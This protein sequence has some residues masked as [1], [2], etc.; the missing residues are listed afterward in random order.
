MKIVTY[1]IRYALGLDG[2]YDYDRITDAVKGADIIA[3]QEVERHW[4]RSEMADQV[5]EI[6]R[7]LPDYHH[8]YFPALDVDASDQIENGPVQNRRRQFGPMLLSRYPIL[9]I[10]RHNLPK[11]ATSHALN[12]DTGALECVIDAPMGPI[13][14]YSLHL[15]ASS[16]REKKAQLQH[17]MDLHRSSAQRGSAWT[18]SGPTHDPDEMKNYIAMDWSNGEDL[19]LTPV[20]TVLLGD[21]NMTP[22]GSDYCMVVGEHDVATGRGLHADG[23]ADSWNF[24]N[25]RVDDDGHTWWPDPPNRTPGVP[26]RLD[27]CFVSPSLAHNIDHAWVDES[28]NGSDH[29]PYWVEVSRG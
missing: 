27:Y 8:A 3:L 5:S 22:E 19:P 24:A 2:V 29:K 14:A 9:E 17:L 4:R 6:S 26:L 1:N 25:K 23:F 11:I 10:R 16:P 18:G 15:S 20:D 12:I 28:A 7:R 13:R 21:F